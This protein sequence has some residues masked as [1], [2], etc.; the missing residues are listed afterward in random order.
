VAFGSAFSHYIHHHNCSH[1]H[2]Y[3]HSCKR[4]PPRTRK[5]A[6]GGTA[7]ACALGVRA[8]G[9]LCSKVSL[10]EFPFRDLKRHRIPLSCEH[11]LRIVTAV[12]HSVWIGVLGAAATTIAAA[13][14]A[15]TA[16]AAGTAGATEAVASAICTV[17]AARA[18]KRS[19]LKRC[20]VVEFPFRDLEHHRLL[21]SCFTYQAR[22]WN[23]TSSSTTQIRTRYGVGMVLACPVFA[24]PQETG[25][26]LT[27]KKYGALEL[28][29]E[30]VVLKRY[31]SEGNQCA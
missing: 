18:L 10:V 17:S 24:N 25:A 23:H 30:H 9:T 19:K 3:S 2:R 1:S 11:T 13:A 4:N 16:G 26:S 28:C 7:A 27:R 22:N 31:R 8:I 29:A 12:V 5:T 21:S 15:A 20:V 14:A 6:A